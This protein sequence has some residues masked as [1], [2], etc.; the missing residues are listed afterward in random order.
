LINVC[1]F[2]RQREVFSVMRIA[3]SPNGGASC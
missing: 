3:T 1:H 2:E